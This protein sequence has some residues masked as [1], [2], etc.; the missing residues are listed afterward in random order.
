MDS[1]MREMMEAYLKKD[2]SRLHMPGHKGRLGYPL[3]DAA[4]YDLTEAGGLD[5][6]YESAGGIRET[7]E[8]YARLY[9]AHTTLLSAGGATLCIQAMLALAAQRGDTIIASRRLH[10]SAVNAM[11]LLRLRPVWLYPEEG[12]DCLAGGRV[13][14]AAVEAALAGCPQAAAVYIT[15]PDYYGQLCD[16]AAIAA[17]CRR[18]GVPLLVDNA[19]GAHLRFLQPDLHPITL[20]ATMCCDSLHKTMPVLTGGAL[21]HIADAGFAAEAKACMALF[22]STSPSY[23]IMLSCSDCLGFLGQGAA[24]AFQSTA[25][26]GAALEALAAQR[27]FVPLSGLRD[28]TKVVLSVYPFA[29]G[30]AVFA[31][32]L[33]A[34]KIEPEYVD[35]AYA[36]LML[37]PFSTER[38][39]GRIR[40]FLQHV[41]LAPAEGG[42]AP[43]RI[44]RPAQQLALWQAVLAPG[45]TVPLAQAVGRVAAAAVTP[46]PP[47]VPQV[48]PGEQIDADTADILKS[49]GVQHIKVVK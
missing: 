16:I 41:R 43:V 15:S 3:A 42:R 38:D 40:H 11:A 33:R 44:A 17:V 22:G 48:M 27:G 32:L 31:D 39:I 7:E 35:D 21:L 36:V 34:Y 14:P 2:L 23:L 47:G 30:G 8:A 10:V 26:G 20:G 1:P 37:S 4:R 18:Y 25:E 19:H 6:L 28:R 45:E 5:S 29:C 9:G 12:P 24:L 49:Y 46:C 13:T